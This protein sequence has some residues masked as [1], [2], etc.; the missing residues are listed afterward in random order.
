MHEVD[1]AARRHRACSSGTETNILPDGSP[2]YDDDLLAQLDWVVAIGAHVASGW[3]RDE[4]T[5]R[6]V[7]RSSTRWIDAIGH[8][9]GPQDR[10]RA[11][12]TT[13][14]STRVFE[15]A[16]RT[17]TML[18]INSAPDR[19]DLNDVHARA[20]AAGGREDRH[21]LRRAR[22]HDARASRAGAWRPRGAPG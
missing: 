4:M 6:I 15:A 1:D 20:A 2:D 12:R 7:A 16:A 3:P 8:L 14:T 5:A 22:R 9:T 11:R 13:S 10:A 18:E 19:R 17:G 21:R